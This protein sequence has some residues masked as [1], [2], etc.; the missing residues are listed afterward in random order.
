MDL[1]TIQD[2]F[3]EVICDVKNGI[4]EQ[5]KFW[6]ARRSIE[7]EV[8]QDFWYIDV[9]KQD[10][11]N[12][13]GNLK[14]LS[15]KG[16]NYQLQVDREVYNLQSFYKKVK[17]TNSRISSVAV[18]SDS[19][20]LIVGT[21]KGE[22]IIYNLVTDTI[23]KKI[24]EA[25]FEDVT[26]LKFFPSD[27]VIMS[28][29]I[30]LKIKIWGLT[31]EL[32]RTMSNQ[33]KEITEIGLLG[34]TGRNFISG[35]KDGSIDI[36][37]CG[38]GQ[39][40]Y[41][42]R[43]IQNN[44]DPV[45]CFVIGKYE[46]SG[47]KI[48]ELEFETGN[49][50]AYVGFDSGIIQQFNIGDH[51]QTRVRFEDGKAGVS[52]IDISDEILVSGYKDGQLKFWNIATEVIICKYQLNSHFPIST[53]KVLQRKGDTISVLVYNGPE[54]LLKLEIDLNNKVMNQT[55]LIGMEENFSVYSVALNQDN[56][57]IGGDQLTV[58]Q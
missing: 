30:D 21:T 58:Y 46:S 6:V 41:S 23:E 12:D 33:V 16:K 5:D 11:K 31:G 14:F 10:M 8:N 20:H 2:S 34:K 24:P 56:I 42:L 57:I 36:W 4:L 1:L 22:L 40:I 18:S 47:S 19:K 55:Y 54:T 29:G 51:C 48:S 26:I 39:L 28:V 49:Q 50:C 44:N 52:S 15:T 45:N 17:L 53:V 43:R 25:H 13:V 27:K 38:Q 7:S 37:E 3:E 32:V 9:T 35:S